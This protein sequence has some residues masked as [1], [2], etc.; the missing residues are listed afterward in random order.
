MARLV[1]HRYVR[2]PNNLI[3]LKAVR[4]IPEQSQRSISKKEPQIDRY[5]EEANRLDACDEIA[6]FLAT[7]G[8]GEVMALPSI[9]TLTR[10]GCPETLKIRVSLDKL[11]LTDL[12][13]ELFP[14]GP[15]ERYGEGV[16]EWYLMLWRI[17][18]KSEVHGMVI[19]NKHSSGTRR[20][21]VKIYD[22]SHLQEYDLEDLVIALNQSRQP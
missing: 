5:N 14:V 17:F 22:N 10:L 20:A 12:G 3:V 8:A 19:D 16:N 18:K 13:T 7:A 6:S 15:F 1:K 9:A 4:D 21:S 2:G 11:E